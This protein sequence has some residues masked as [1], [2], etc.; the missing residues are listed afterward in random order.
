[1]SEGVGAF[2]KGKCYLILLLV[3]TPWFHLAKQILSHPT[4]TLRG[5]TWGRSCLVVRGSEGTRKVVSPKCFRDN[6]P[7]PEDAGQVFSRGCKSPHSL[8]VM[9]GTGCCQGVCTCLFIPAPGAC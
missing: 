1:M 6:E 5:R 7:W 4:R 9:H 8:S 3:V 2:V